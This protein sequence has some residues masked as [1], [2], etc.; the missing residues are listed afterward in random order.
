MMLSNLAAPAPDFPEPHNEE[1]HNEVF[2]G[3]ESLDE[4]E[5]PDEITLMRMMTPQATWC[6]RPWGHALSKDDGF[7]FD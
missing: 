5:D 3:E 4:L 2:N 7:F 1:P 6:M